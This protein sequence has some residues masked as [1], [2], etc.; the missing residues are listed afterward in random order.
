MAFAQSSIG[1][2][3][4]GFHHVGQ[5][6]FKLLTLSD[7]PALI[8]QGAGIIVEKGFHYVGQAGLELLTSG[9][10]PTLAFQSAEITGIL[11]ERA[12]ET[13]GSAINIQRL[14]VHSDDSLTL[15][16]SRFVTRLE[17]SGAISAH[18]N[19]CLSL[20]NRD[21]SRDGILPCWPGWS[22]SLDLMIHLPRLSK[23][24][25]LR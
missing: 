8:S 20:L 15:T 18:C 3:E 22:R 9:D 16:E 13:M 25:G 24:L 7:P 11:L 19:L 12:K 10:L 1:A 21:N 17:C 23:V 4:T 5:A 2:V 6:G 14:P